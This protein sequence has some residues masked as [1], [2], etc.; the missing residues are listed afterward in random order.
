MKTRILYAITV[1]DKSGMRTLAYANQFR[2]FKQTR[3]DAEMQLKEWQANSPENLVQIF[4]ERACTLEVRPVECYRNGDAISVWFDCHDDTKE[5][6]KFSPGERVRM[7]PGEHYPPTANRVRYGVVGAITNKPGMS[8]AA[9]N[10]TNFA[11]EWAYSIY[12]SPNG[13]AMWWT[14][15]RLEKLSR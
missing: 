1:C 9:E 15:A 13:G 2:N 12:Q 8:I 5:T 6:P 7:L 14:A 10:R 3:F 11:G 4:G